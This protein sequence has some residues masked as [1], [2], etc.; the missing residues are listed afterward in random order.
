MACTSSRANAPSPQDGSVRAHP[1][2]ASTADAPAPIGSPAA[3]TSASP[4][5]TGSPAASTSDA[6]SAIRSSAASDAAPAIRFIEDDYGRALAEARARGVPLFVDAWAPWCHTCLSMRA[7]VFPDDRLRALSPRFVW[8]SLD[9]E[10]QQNEAIVSK[11][12]VRVLPTLFVIEPRDERVALA[13]PG[14]LTA[15]EL[16]TLLDDARSGNGPKGP[17]AIDAAVARSSSQGRLRECAVMAS[18]EAPAMPPG[19]ALADVIRSGIDCTEKL[20]DNPDDRARL[21]ELATLGER[22]ASDPSQPILADDRSDLYDYTLSAYRALDRSDSGRRLAHAWA[23]FLEQQAARAATP[24][25]RAV[26]D[27]HRLLACLALGEP[28]RAIAFLRQSEREFPDDFDPPA[29]LATAYLAMKHFDDALAASQRALELAYGPRKLRLWSLQ[30]DVRV[31]MGDVAGARAALRAALDFAD[32]VHPGVAYA[33]EIA[34]LT[35]RLA[36]LR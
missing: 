30:A 11:L 13:W 29:R 33:N 34:T 5:P 18:R 23:A 4:V 36:A 32:R 26:F 16:V 27:A 14:S 19:T 20:L 2:A 12:G 8:L 6:A 15:A 25:Q 21:A 9:T 1:L 28:E 3:S 31:A 24:S 10:R 35:K 22:V 17:L 7:F